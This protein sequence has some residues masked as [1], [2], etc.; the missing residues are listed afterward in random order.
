MND[1]G[2]LEEI[3]ASACEIFVVLLCLTEKHV[4]YL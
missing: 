4:S 2:T 1:G 3:I